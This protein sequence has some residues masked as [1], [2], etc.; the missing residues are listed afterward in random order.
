MTTTCPL[1]AYRC[2]HA[3][4]FTEQPVAEHGTLFYRLSMLTELV[5][6]QCTVISRCVAEYNLAWALK[7]LQYGGLS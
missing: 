5:Y 1:W 2:A 4:I 3:R 7:T 6:C